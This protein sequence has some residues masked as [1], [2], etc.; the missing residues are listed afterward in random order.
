MFRRGSASSQTS[1]LDAPATASPSSST[2]FSLRRT[3]SGRSSRGQ[4][5][6]SSQRQSLAPS[7]SLAPGTSTERSSSPPPSYIDS[8]QPPAVGRAGA[9]G[10]DDDQY[11]F[12]HEFNTIFLIDD[13]ASMHDENRWGETQQAIR[14]ILP[15]CMKYDDDGIDVYFFNHRSRFGSERSRGAAAEGYLNIKDP[16]VIENMFRGIRPSGRT[17]TGKSLDRILRPYLDHYAAKVKVTKDVDCVSPINI[18]VIT[19]GEADDDPESII[20]AAARRLDN[21][22]APPH[23]IGIQFFQV[24][25]NPDAKT[26]LHELD[27]ELGQRHGIRDMVDTSTF[28]DTKGRAGPKLTSDGILK[29]VLGSVKR[30]LDR[31]VVIRV[32]APQS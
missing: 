7:S 2:G 5:S 11:A 19:D 10:P 9:D 22:H 14:A 29:V 17:P 8:V 24:G 20:A 16:K 25:T 3:L 31:K 18:I 23:Q 1:N 13:S 26:A 4:D 30:K 21:L 6:S 12:L 27:D 28:D 32:D 15:V